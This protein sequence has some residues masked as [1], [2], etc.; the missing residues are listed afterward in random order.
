MKTKHLTYGENRICYDSPEMWV[1][2][3]KMQGC[4]LEGSQGS[5]V[6]GGDVEDDDVFGN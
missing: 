3:V 1:I 6:T 5:E 4:I 2:N